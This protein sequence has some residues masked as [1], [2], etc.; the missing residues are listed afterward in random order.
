MGYESWLPSIPQGFACGG[1]GRGRRRG[2][3]SRGRR[4]ARLSNKRWRKVRVVVGEI[5]VHLWR[6]K[7]LWRGEGGRVREGG[8]RGRW[9]G[10][11]RWALS[12]RRVISLAMTSNTI[13]PTSD[14]SVSL[15]PRASLLSPSDFT[16]CHF[17][18]RSLT[19]EGIIREDLPSNDSRIQRSARTK[20]TINEETIFEI[21]PFRIKFLF[22]FPLISFHTQGVYII[23]N[24]RKNL[25]AEVWEIRN[26]I[27]KIDR[28]PTTIQTNIYSS[29]T[30]IIQARKI[31]S[32][33]SWNTEAGIEI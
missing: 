13:Q 25:F 12:K 5:A 22:L 26:H 7:R 1:G 27:F 6:R 33:K 29:S 16:I 18:N 30:K 17:R 31:N 21:F 11:E 19:P 10:G 14:E 28:Y 3:I 2:W 9:R 23:Q 8:K 4:N 32:L 20:W 24:A 15:E